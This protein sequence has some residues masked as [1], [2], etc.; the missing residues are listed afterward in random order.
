MIN[1]KKIYLTLIIIIISITLI[2]PNFSNYFKNENTFKI[3]NITLNK[4][5]LNLIIKDEI[6]KIKIYIKNNNIKNNYSNKQLYNIILNKII[7][8]ILLENYI[9]NLNIIINDD[10]IKNFI[11]NNKDFYKV[12]SFNNKK[13]SNLLKKGKITNNE[14]INLI[15]LSLKNNEFLNSVINTEIFIPKIINSINKYISEER[16]YKISYINTDKLINY[17]FIKNNKDT[18]NIKL[19]KYYLKLPITKKNNLSIN[20]LNNL[21]KNKFINKNINLIKYPGIS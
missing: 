21:I 14:Y 13:Y 5:L 3:N 10:Q 20:I 18:A 9:N 16:N 19:V 1:K 4:D 11:S 6:K 7:K 15:K 12:K 17:Y 8:K 2:I